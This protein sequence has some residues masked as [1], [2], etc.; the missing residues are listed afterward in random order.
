M[1]LAF[2]FQGYSKPPA[3]T[4]STPTPTPT[5]TPTTSPSPTPTDPSTKPINI[6]TDKI[7][8]EALSAH[9]NYRAKYNA[10][11]LTWDS[12][13]A[14]FAADW[15]SKC[16]W[17]HSGGPNGGASSDGLSLVIEGTHVL[18]RTWLPEL[19]L[20]LSPTRSTCG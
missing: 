8:D 11:A 4:P 14:T 20:S 9:N 2:S 7:K 16:F 19:V 15:G 5:P 12:S 18:Q 3:V 13:L 10:P 1:N 17:G 6:V